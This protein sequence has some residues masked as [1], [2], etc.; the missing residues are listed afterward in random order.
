MEAYAVFEQIREVA[1]SYAE[2]WLVQLF[3]NHPQH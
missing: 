1:S 3:L 2:Q